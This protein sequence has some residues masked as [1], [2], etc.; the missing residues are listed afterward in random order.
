[1]NNDDPDGNVRYMGADPNNYVLFNDE[2]WRIIGVFD[3]A[4][5][6]GGPTEKRIKLIRNESIGS[7]SWDSSSLNVNSGWGVNEWSQA[8]IMITLNSGA[9]WNRTSGTCYNSEGDSIINCDFS[10][11]GLTSDSKKYIENVVWNTGAVSYENILDKTAS[12]ASVLY[13]GERSVNTGKFCSS[14]ELCN[15]NVARLSTWKGYVGLMYSSDFVYSTSGGYTMN[16]NAC[17]SSLSSNWEDSM[18]D[19]CKNNSWLYDSNVPQW[20]IAP[21]QDATYSSLVYD[22]NAEGFV[23]YNRACNC[24]GVRPSIYLKSTVKITGGEGTSTSPYTL[25]L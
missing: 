10:S 1:M 9:Y 16:R 25:A 14:N 3:V 7:Y 21:G 13:A 19:D 15:D 17:L 24:L 5:E 20:T 4:S 23:N 18:Y 8:D 22:I 12:I 2:L 11:N 6:E